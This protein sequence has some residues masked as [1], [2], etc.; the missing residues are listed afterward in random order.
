[1][2][3]F[4][5]P[6]IKVDERPLLQR[7]LVVL[8]ERHPYYYKAPLEQQWKWCNIIAGEVKGHESA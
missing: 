8:R 6:P 1:M 2:N 4:S 5:G 7:V 3:Y